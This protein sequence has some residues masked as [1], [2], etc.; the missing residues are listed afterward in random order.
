MHFL[1]QV[2]A[3]TKLGSY[4][5]LLVPGENYQVTASM[6]G[7]QSK[8]TEIHLGG[9]KGA[10][11]DFILDPLEGEP[12]LVTNVG[13]CDCDY[14]TG[15]HIILVFCVFLLFVCYFFRRKLPFKSSTR[16]IKASIV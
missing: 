12:P 6:S 16:S 3:T 11:L 15:P 10:S 1:L 9:D 14:A 7:F 5:R 2:N 13:K 8:T 4:H